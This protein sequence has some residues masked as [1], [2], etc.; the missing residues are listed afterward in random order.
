[1]ITVIR[2]FKSEAADK[3]QKQLSENCHPFLVIQDKLDAPYLIDH[4]NVYQA[5]HFEPY[6]QGLVASEVSKSILNSVI[7]PDH[8]EF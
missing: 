6:I 4:G 8:Y 3:L 7:D 5:D 1:M 2:P